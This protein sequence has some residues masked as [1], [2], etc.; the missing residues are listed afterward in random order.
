MNHPYA[1]L[2]SIYD[3]TV[4]KGTAKVKVVTKKEHT[5]SLG[6]VHGGLIYSLADIAFELASNS[7]EGI[8]A[9]G[10]TTNMQFHKAAKVGDILE[11]VAR[12]IHLGKKLATYLIEVSCGE[13]L[14]ASFT[15]T[16]YRIS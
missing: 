14:L 5:N 11:A 13:N 16:V 12:E 6:Y 10:I 9:V 1:N 15:G 7:Y 4:D 3:T 2:L 8:D